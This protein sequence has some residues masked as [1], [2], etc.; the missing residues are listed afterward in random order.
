MIRIEH[1]FY[2]IPNDEQLMDQIRMVPARTW[3]SAAK[4]W[5]VPYVV[6]SYHVLLD[7]GFK[8]KHLA[9]PDKGGYNISTDVTNEY[10]FLTTMGMKLDIERCRA[11]P[12][13]KR[14]DQ[15][16]A[17]WVIRPTMKNTEYLRGAFPTAIWT[18]KAEAIAHKD[19][20]SRKKVLPKDFKFKLEPFPHQLEDFHRSRDREFYAHFW[21]QG[22]G[23]TKI[24]ID[25][26]AYNVQKGRVNGLLVI[27]PNA[28]K[29]TW[30]DDELPTH[31]PD[32]LDTDVFVWDTKTKKFA[33]KWILTP[34]KDRR[35]KI[36]IMNV[37]ALSHASGVHAADLFVSRWNSMVAVDESSTISNHKAT[38]TK[39]LTK[40]GKKAK[41]RRIADGTPAT[42]SPM[43]FFAQSLFLS[44]SILGTNYYA[45]RTKYA[46]MGGWQGKQI[47][48]YDNLDQLQMILDEFSSRVLKTD[49]FKDMPPQLFTKRQVTLTAE[50]RRMYDELKDELLT[51]TRHG[52]VQ[53]EHTITKLLRMHQVI[54][55]FMPATMF[56]TD[57]ETG[58]VEPVYL[59]EQPPIPGGNPKLEELLNI[60]ASMKEKLIIYCRFKPEMDAIT[61]ELRKIYGKDNVVEMRGGMNKDTRKHAKDSFQK[62]SAR[63]MVAQSRAAGRGLTLTACHTVVY[64]SNDFSLRIRLQSQ[65]RVH[66]YGQQHAVTYID[67]VSDAP[68]DTHLLK[69]LRKKKNLSDKIHGDPTFSWL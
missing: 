13:F 11:I 48:G 8:I 2:T 62:G 37:E 23:K 29:A 42:E 30:E 22:T 53:V 59:K 43:E 52:T 68:L 41:I 27:A 50:Q 49:V 33:E 19:D 24:M 66:R 20:P 45:Y 18:S 36:F 3:N 51:E 61:R 63:F 54:G 26:F 7:L 35:V 1:G 9:K 14:F 12:E 56:T 58:E 17:G 65:D 4:V 69:T 34:S 64:Y 16:N 28:V 21:D 60:A 10:L 25:T 55:G 15:M 31:T 6:E 57:E 5:Q 47:V 46:I 38:R 67:L 32:W 44:P 40:I 39:S